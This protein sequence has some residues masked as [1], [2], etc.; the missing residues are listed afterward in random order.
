M[1]NSLKKGP[2]GPELI[3]LYWPALVKFGYL[4]LHSQDSV[5][6]G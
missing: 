2:E 6:Y 4:P 5:L 1:S 3:A